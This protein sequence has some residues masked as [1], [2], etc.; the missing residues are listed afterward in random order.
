MTGPR[1][2]VPARVRA[3]LR[4]ARRG[5]RLQGRDPRRAAAAWVAVNTALAGVRQ[6]PSLVELAA[7]VDPDRYERRL[8]LA[9]T[10]L[11]LALALVVLQALV[12]RLLARRE[13]PAVA[14]GPAD[15]DDPPPP[16]RRPDMPA[17]LTRRRL[18][19]SAA[20]LAAA[21][22]WALGQG[23]R[24]DVA[25]IMLPSNTASAGLAPPALRGHPDHHI[26]ADP[27]AVQL[28]PE[29]PEL[30]AHPFSV[31]SDGELP[32][33][34]RSPSNSCVGTC[35]AGASCSSTTPPAARVG[36][37]PAP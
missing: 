31:P 28:S 35:P 13:Q 30:F 8:E 36:P 15:A 17:D 4:F 3:V 6:G 29:D 25:E 34:R 27:D 37:S 18:L 26:E 1:G 23:S 11:W 21:P 19:A 16:S 7:E 2:A 5:G 10:L 9:T 24:L 32:S 12:A 33:S 22:R 14:A 20:A